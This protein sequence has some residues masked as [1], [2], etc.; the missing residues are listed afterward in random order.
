MIPQTLSL[1][2]YLET[3]GRNFNMFKKAFPHAFLAAEALNELFWQLYLGDVIPAPKAIWQRVVREMIFGCL[4]S[5]SHAFIMSASGLDEHAMTSSRRSIEFACYIAKIY[6][7]DERAKLWEISK[8]DE[9]TKKKFAGEFGIPKAYF[10]EKYSHLKLLLV[11]H[12]HASDFAVHANMAMLAQKMK[13]EEMSY[14]MS[15]FDNFRDTP[16]N[17]ATAIQTGFLVLEALV[18]SLKDLIQDYDHY[19][20]QFKNLQELLEEVKLEVIKYEEQAGI[21]PELVELIKANPSL[22]DKKFEQLK[23]LHSMSKIS[24]RQTKSN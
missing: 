17:V 15:S 16:L 24:P 22:L 3:L 10:S 9:E 5:W 1:A 11:I 18:I 19:T 7:S 12:D 6:G 4:N 2:N 13:E 23:Q 14:T 20:S 8:N 21:E